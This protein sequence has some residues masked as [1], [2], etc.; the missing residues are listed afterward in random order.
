MFL[1]LYRHLFN[2]DDSVEW[3]EK[4][5]MI[6]RLVLKMWR[7][8]YNEEDIGCF[9]KGEVTRYE[10]MWERVTRDA[11]VPRQQISGGGEVAGE[12]FQ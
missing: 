2:T 5:T 1:E 12:T 10:T 8:G 7:S 3:Q 9:V 4:A 6:N 11:I